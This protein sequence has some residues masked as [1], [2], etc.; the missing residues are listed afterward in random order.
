[1]RKNKH[2]KTGDK[3]MNIDIEFLKQ[4]FKNNDDFI[5]REIKL[6]K[7]KIYIAFFE[8]LTD[9]QNIYN[10]IIKHIY[11]SFDSKNKIKSVQSVIGGPKITKVET[12]GDLF[13]LLENGFCLIFY[14]DEKYAIEVKAN[15]D[16]GITISQSEPNMFGPK[17]SF[18]ENYQKNLGVIKRRIKTQSLKVDSIT[19]GTY[20]KT[21]ISLIYL[22][23]KV[24]K[25][26]LKKI[27]NR[28]NENA[29]KEV[30]DSYDL[31]K[32]LELNK[33]FPT[34][35]KTEKPALASNYILQ[36]KII[37]L[38]DNTPFVLII[39]AKLNDFVNPSTTDKFVKILRFICLF[40]TILTP[41]LYIALI[42]FNQESIPPSLLINFSQQRSGVPFPA[43]VEAVIMLFICEILRETDLRFPNSYGS[44]ASILGALILGDAAVQ[45][46]IVSPIMIIIVAISFITSLIFTDIKLVSSIR[47]MRASFLLIASILGLYG[48][49]VAFIIA[50]FI[51]ANVKMYGGEYLWKNLY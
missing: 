9:T 49:S 21:K 45:A 7:G 2:N 16:R 5:V 44:S 12:D 19:R 37:V 48:L 13:N 4:T 8:S 39:D 38:I 11:N 51:I 3:N 33:V 41:A 26:A 35:M 34:L 6:K 43:I 32:E 17:D 1:M 24:D 42:N 23:D 46:G 18:C 25:K 50:M 29:D 47:I 28:I 27:K 22:E 40:M 36:G 10:Y 30:L 31:S 20:T 15:I 14:K